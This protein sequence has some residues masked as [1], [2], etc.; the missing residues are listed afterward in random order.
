M[1]MLLTKRK[2]YLR[3]SLDLTLDWRPLF[4]EIKV[5]VLPRESGLMQTTNLKR[6]I[7][8]LIGIGSFAQLYFDPEDI[9]AMLEEILP[10][11]T[12]SSTEGAFVVIGLLNMLLPTGPPPPSRSDLN[13]QHFLPTFFHL[14]SLVNRSRTVDVALVDLLSRLARDSLPSKQ[15]GFSEFGIFTAEQSTLITTAVLRLLEIPVGQST[16]PYSA[17]VDITA[18]TV[19]LL[20]L[21]PHETPVS[22]HIALWFV[23]SLSPACLGKKTSV[24]SLLET[25]IQAIETFFHP[26]NSGDWTH[27]L[28][29][30]VFHLADFFVMRWNTER[31]GEV[32]VSEE[33]KLNE[34]LRKR[35]VLCLREVIFMGIYAK[36]GTAMSYSL[37]TLQALAF[38]EPNLIL[39][40]ALQRIYP[41]MQGL[42]EVH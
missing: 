14:W 42:V 34:P 19:F 1:F 21:D 41:S 11:F 35:F 8:T 30:L 15:V 9:P 27:T 12:M 39:P 40:G 32:E 17:L 33:R 26:S 36:S 29:Q 2:H 37:S 25:L 28:A 38:L 3:P 6:N 31:N 18:D 16:S 13:P 23:M 22:R 10:H 5:F 4:R 24:L 7:E 20:G